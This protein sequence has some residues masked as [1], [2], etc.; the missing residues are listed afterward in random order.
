MRTIAALICLL[1]AS[2]AAPS[3]AHE[4]TNDCAAKVAKITNT[5]E[6]AKAEKECLAKVASP[7]NVAKHEQHDKQEHCDTNAKGMKLKGKDK[8][9]YLAHCYHENDFDKNQLPHPA[10]AK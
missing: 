5:E 3:F 4:M 6:R 8:T 1:L 2:F 9:D 10:A 7:E